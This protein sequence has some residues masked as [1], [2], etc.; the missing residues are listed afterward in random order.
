MKRPCLDCG[1]LTDTNRCPDHQRQQQRAI[2]ARRGS[3]TERGYGTPWRRARKA[4][5]RL[6]PY[7]VDCGHEGSADNPLTVDHIVPLSRGGTHDDDNLTT[8][9]RR[10]NSAKGAR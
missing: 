9:C 10:H 2:D 4:V 8:R 7:C 6:I 1:R 3:P 5:L